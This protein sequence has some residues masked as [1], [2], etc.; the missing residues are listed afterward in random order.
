MSAC[1]VVDLQSTDLKE[2]AIAVAV[3]DDEDADDA[4][5]VEIVK[6]KIVVAVRLLLL[7]KVE[8]VLAFLVFL[9]IEFVLEGPAI[10]QM[11]VLPFL[12]DFVYLAAIVVLVLALLFAVV[13]AD[14]VDADKICSAAFVFN[15]L[16]KNK[17]QKK[18]K[19]KLVT[20]LREINWK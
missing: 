17:E 5:V 20:I 13:V 2:L 16:W 3:D 10:V 15:R 18:P 19:Q 1:A 14:A 11:A 4:G 6:R 9:V 12:F 7:P 8:E